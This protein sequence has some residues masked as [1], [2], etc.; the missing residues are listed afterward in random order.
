MDYQN[1][2]GNKKKRNHKTQKQGKV[3]LTK[4][5]KQKT[6]NVRRK[7]RIQEWGKVK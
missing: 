4:E 5:K 7:T 2:T 6:K 1:K 3:T